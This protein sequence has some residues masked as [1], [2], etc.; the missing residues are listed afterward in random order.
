MIK[1]LFLTIL[2]T[3]VL[4]GG[5]SAEKL[6]LNCKFI[7]GISK[8]YNTNI[9]ETLNGYEDELIV[10]DLKKNEIIEGP[11][12]IENQN[13]TD[14]Q[15]EITWRNIIGQPEKNGLVNQVELNRVNGNL[16]IMTVATS[17]KVNLVAFKNY[18]CKQ[19][20]DKLF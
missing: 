4:S 3:L 19:T 15:N 17:N 14:Q 12:L 11:H 7:S 20:E 13:F 6:N 5:A 9:E 16:Q 10:I 1:K 8:D 2:F 18:K